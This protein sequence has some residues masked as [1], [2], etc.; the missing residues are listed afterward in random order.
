MYCL[1][2]LTLAKSKKANNLV[3]VYQSLLYPLHEKCPYLE[4][5][6]SVFSPVWTEFREIL[7]I[8][9]FFYS[10]LTFVA[11]KKRKQ[12]TVQKEKK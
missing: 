9:P 11:F 12:F 2:E 8:S 3:K 7:C 10:A 4:F 6:W 1:E 5:F